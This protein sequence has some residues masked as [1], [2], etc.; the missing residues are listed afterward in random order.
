M[1]MQRQQTAPIE[2]LAPARDAECA[3]AAVLHGA[4]AVYIGGPG[5]GARQA[6]GNS[7]DDIASLCRFAHLYG[8]RVYVTLNTILY[9]AELA[10]AEALVWQLYRADVDALIVQDAALLRMNLPPIALHASTQMDNCTV[11]KARLLEAMGFSQ[12]VLARETPL[13]LT[14]RIAD[15]VRVPLEAFVHGALCVSY[16]GRC[17]ASQYCFGR[18]ANRGRCAQFC[19][20][21]FDLVDERGR[22]LVRNRYLLSLRDMNRSASLEEVMDAG[23]RS[24]KIE[25]RLKSAEYVKNVTAAYRREIDRILERRGEYRRA[26][27]GRSSYDF[28]PDLSRSFNRRFTDYFLHGERAEIASP[29]TPKAVGRCVGTAEQT[30]GRSLVIR[31]TGA[32]VPPIVAGDGL[33][34][35]DP[36]RGLCGF[37]VNKAEGGRV[38]PA[39]PVDIP[40]GARL[41]RSL[42]FDF[43]RRLS[44]SVARRTLQTD[45]ALREVEGGYVVD[46]T[47]E[48][49]CSISRRFEAPHDTARTPQDEAM[50]RVLG[51]LG[52][53]PFEARRID[54]LTH[55][56]RFIPASQLAA[57]R[58]EA[59]ELLIRA[60]HAS[61]V[62]DRRRP[63]HD[64]EVRSLLPQTLPFTANVANRLAADYYRSHGVQ[65]VA[66]AFE[67]AAPEGQTVLMTCRHCIRHALNLCLRRHPDRRSLA[68]RLPDGRTFPLRFDCA[69]CEMQVLSPEPR[70]KP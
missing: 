35:A 56:P 46:L 30:R 50:R 67:C 29:L 55:G 65:A 8:V 12:I 5:F 47:D 21:A 62:R 38:Y 52:D 28:T 25:G 42:D 43:D 59:A 15:A 1:V 53:T 23:V 34:Y 2:L 14:R 66:P 13:S 41:Y 60:H 36:A 39:Q 51:K 33:C 48:S 26:S 27:F 40:Q 20:L 32:D 44:R 22:R 24:F 10:E 17:Y 54:I 16:S 64:E 4:D 49:G 7:V 69:R 70:K 68:L 31:M 63:A 45:I 57:W 9:D 58:R 19:R 6:A 18:S 37:R 11:E 61:Y 3:R